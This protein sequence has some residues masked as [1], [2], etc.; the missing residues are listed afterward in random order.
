MRPLILPNSLL[1]LLRNLIIHTLREIHPT[2]QGQPLDH[3]LRILHLESRHHKVARYAQT[4]EPQEHRYG[5]GR[6]WE[7]QSA[8]HVAYIKKL[9]IKH[10][11]RI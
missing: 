8:M 7:K 9:G 2:P 1:P 5:V 6:Q 4:V 11:R 3:N 10:G